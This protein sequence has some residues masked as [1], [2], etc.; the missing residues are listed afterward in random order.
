MNEPLKLSSRARGRIE[1]LGLEFLARFYAAETRRRPRN[2][3]ALAELGHVLTQLERYEDGL[4]VDRQLAR[5][6]PDNP[7]ARY[8]L[9]CSLALV[10][11]AE[12]ALDELDRAVDLG[13]DDVEHLVADTD[14]A[15][16]H[17]ERRFRALVERLR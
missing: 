12:E 10:G 1:N 3:A 17:E 15:S 2:V 7:T 8:N 6:V 11:L 16:L 14:L 5:L 4:A 13:Y 9:A